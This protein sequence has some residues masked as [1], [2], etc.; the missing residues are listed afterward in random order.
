MFYLQWLHLNSAKS[1]L[2]EM[3]GEAHCVVR[4]EYPALLLLNV[5]LKGKSQMFEIPTPVREVTGLVC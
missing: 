2:F 3:E 5:S 1:L 4:L